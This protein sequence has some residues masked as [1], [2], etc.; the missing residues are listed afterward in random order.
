MNSNVDKLFKEKLAGHSIQPTPQAW[1]R[2]ESRVTKKNS[3]VTTWKIAAAI[4]LAGILTTFILNQT[5]RKQAPEIAKENK[6]N[7]TQPSKTV[8]EPKPSQEIAKKAPDVAVRPTPAP[9]V[10]KQKQPVEKIIQPEAT[11]EPQPVVIVP[12]ETLIA[13]LQPEPVK[14]KSRVL[15]Y[16]L[17][18]VGTKSD[19]STMAVTDEVKKSGLQKVISVAMEVRNSENALGEL[20]EAKDELFALDF[21]KDKNKSK[22]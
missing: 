11:V 12:E 14:A 18:T 16:T 10:D 9:K 6:N 8:H 19:P 7:L 3:F 22:N 4:L 13:E 2:I 15:V 1:E 17:P 5:F 20:R 21:R